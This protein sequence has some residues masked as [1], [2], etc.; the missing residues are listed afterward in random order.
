MSGNRSRKKRCKNVRD[1]VMVWNFS[2]K[3]RIK[4]LFQNPLKD[5]NI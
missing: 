2:E 1:S 4:P 3:F 5:K